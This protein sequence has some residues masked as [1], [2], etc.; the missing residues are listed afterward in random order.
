MT[1]RPDTVEHAVQS[2]AR[3]L[4]QKAAEHKPSLFEAKD[5]LGRMIDWSLDRRVSAGRFVSLRRRLAEPGIVQRDRPPSRRIFLARRSCARRLGR[6]RPG[7]SCGHAGGARGAAQRHQP[8]APLYR[9]GEQRP[10]DSGAGEPAQGA[11]GVYPRR[12]R[13][14]DGE[15]SAKRR[16]CSSAISICCADWRRRARIGRHARR[17][18]TR[19]TAKFRGSIYRSSSPRCARASIRSTP[20][21]RLPS[22]KGCASCFARRARLG[23]AITV[24]MEQYAFK[25]LTLEIFRAVLEEE[26]FR[27]AAARGD[28]PASLP[29]RR[30]AGRS[31]VDPLGAPA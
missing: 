16:P 6:S 19:R 15:R 2:L 27:R 4:Y 25:E 31:R 28:R 11:G 10:F 22:A 17:S 26:E 1:T 12:R 14:G 8:G 13:R 3:A 20:T 21:P 7:A 5:L 30:R 24:D 9:R 29:A 23:A 18:T